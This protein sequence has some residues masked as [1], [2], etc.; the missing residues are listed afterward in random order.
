M[1]FR[2]ARKLNQQTVIIREFILNSLID[3]AKTVIPDTRERFGVSRQTVHRHLKA[4]VEKG[5]VLARGETKSRT[6]ALATT[7]S[8]NIDLDVT[9]DTEEDN[10]WT[11]KVRPHIKDVEKNIMEICHYGFT[12]MMNNVIDHA[13][14]KTVRIHIRRTVVSLHISIMDK[15]VGIFKKIQKYFELDDQ[16]QA[17][18]ELSK[19]KL[20]SDANKI[21]RAHV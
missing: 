18:L 21:G 7:F 15:G 20:T 16:R 10:I 1:L 3:G 19:G 13:D 8:T 12:E 11:K 4:L 14:S 5:D 9:E 6:Y 2:S 17:L